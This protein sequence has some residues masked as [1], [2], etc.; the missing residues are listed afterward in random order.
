MISTAKCNMEQRAHR[1]KQ[2]EEN[3][4]ETRL[5]LAHTQKQQ[6]HESYAKAKKAEEEEDRTLLEN[7]LSFE[8][9]LE[10]DTLLH[11]WVLVKSDKNEPIITVV[12]TA[13]IPNTANDSGKLHKYFIQN[14]KILISF[15]CRFMSG[16]QSSNKPGRTI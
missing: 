9:S 6:F 14:I 1:A 2:L 4:R 13:T 8:S 15:Y 11:N 5:K 12:K 7:A 3:L 16:C 10:N